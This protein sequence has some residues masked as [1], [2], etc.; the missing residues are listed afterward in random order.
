[1]AGIKVPSHCVSILV[2]QMEQLWRQ[3]LAYV[4]RFIY[5]THLHSQVCAPLRTLE[6]ILLL[7]LSILDSRDVPC[8]LYV[9]LRILVKKK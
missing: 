5:Q 7:S 3:Q 2:Q 8:T 1:M 6:I 4:D 9:I